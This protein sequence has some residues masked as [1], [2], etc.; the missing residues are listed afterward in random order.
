MNKEKGEE[1]KDGNLFSHV[2]FS[3]IFFKL[4]RKINSLLQHGPVSQEK[5]AFY[6]RFSTFQQ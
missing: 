4:R 5:R 3:P 2:E 1:K 6:L